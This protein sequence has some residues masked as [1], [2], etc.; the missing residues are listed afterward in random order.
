MPV[1]Y[2]PYYP[3]PIEG[4]AILDNFS[5]T[6][7]YKDSYEVKNKLKRGM[8]FYELEKIE[9][10]GSNK[11]NNMLIRGECL[12]A[13]AYLKDKNIKVDLV[14]IDPPF[15]SGANYA[16]KIYLRQN[17]KIAEKEQELKNCKELDLED[18]REFEE[19]MYGDIW[20]KEDYLNWMY[21]NL[22]AIKS[23]MSDTA[24]IYVH[25]DNKMIF[26]VK[27]LM[28]EI[29]GETFFKSMITWDTTLSTIGFKALTDNWIYT[30]NYILFYTK[31]YEYIFNKELKNTLSYSI[32]NNGLWQVTGINKTKKRIP[33]SDIWTDMPGLGSSFAVN[34]QSVNYATQKPETLLERIIKA[35]SNENMIVA[36]FFGGSGVTADVA[37]KLN[38]RFIHVDVGI[39]SIQTARDRLIEDK[40]EFDILEIKDGVSLYRNPQQTM[41]KLKA[42]INGVIEEN[43]L[44]D[45]WFGAIMDSKN[46]LVPIYVP[47]LIDSSFKIMDLTLI[48][49][50][51][52]KHIPNLSND[53][54]KVI[55]Y[56]IDVEDFEDINKFIKEDN[57]TLVEIEFKD[58]KE[59][60]DDIVAEDY[61]EYTINKVSKDLSGAEY[62]I[63]IE[64]FISD[65]VIQKIEK[66]NQNI[67]N[68]STK[69]DKK[70]SPINI[71]GNGLELIEYISIDCS[72]DNGFWK[73][74]TEIKIDKDSK[75][76]LNGK[77][78]KE[79]WNG[80]INSIDKPLRMKIRNI[81]GDENIYIL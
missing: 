58:L 67:I 39:N 22:S 30:S 45:F 41:D 71:S 10:V 69:S 15:A 2:I 20:R 26:Y 4:Q 7:K 81:C 66:Y 21:E 34:T 55:I 44:D 17:P 50:I 57:S 51:V 77:K 25:L 35:S 24:S 52:Y 29:F 28:D 73:S 27:I 47:N 79:Y 12:S 6:L 11:N 49:E 70:I 80:K 64:K 56:Y 61:A 68:Q 48:K 74:D 54:K 72:N 62:Q 63:S 1:K 36:D 53:I 14:Y 75:V 37:N 60:L 76:I 9:Q 19:N 31:S 43:T 59:Y 65:R 38:R 33:I 18:V 40:A 23:I 78:T 46:G 13:C 32:D 3:D 42:L 5:R 8:P 16:K